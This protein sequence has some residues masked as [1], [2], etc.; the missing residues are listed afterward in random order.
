M[1]WGHFLEIKLF[2][3]SGLNL[4]KLLGVY[5]G[6]WLSQVNEVRCLNKHPQSIFTRL[7]PDVIIRFV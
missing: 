6:T 4:T 1:Q 5:L 3:S 2:T 7:G